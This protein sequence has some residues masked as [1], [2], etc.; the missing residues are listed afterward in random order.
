MTKNIKWVDINESKKR[1]LVFTD[2]NSE[3]ESSNDDKSKIVW[4]K[5]KYN[6]NTHDSNPFT[7]QILESTLFDAVMKYRKTLM[8]ESDDLYGISKKN[9]KN[10]S[11]QERGERFF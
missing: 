10:I 3:S 1:K 11:D 5:V 2:L 8:T 6:P 4:E 7:Q 9:M